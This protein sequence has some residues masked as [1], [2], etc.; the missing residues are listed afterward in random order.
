MIIIYKTLTT[1]FSTNKK[2]MDSIAQ[3]MAEQWRRLTPHTPAAPG[4]ECS[5]EVC[6]L[7]HIIG[8]LWQQG[9]KEHVCVRVLCP[10]HPSWANRGTLKRQV[11]NV[12]MCRATGCAHFC[13]EQCSCTDVDHSDGGHVC[14]IS[15]IRYDSIKSD[16][17]FTNHRVTATH[18]ENKDPL[19]LVRDTDFQINQQSMDTIRQQQHHSRLGKCR[20]WFPTN[21]PCTTDKQWA[22]DYYYYVY[23]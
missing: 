3:K 23:Y 1:S 8:G 21:T 10:N 6:N 13:N 15:G 9:D 17:W 22:A 4:H 7:Q 19:K 11:R 2:R 12:Y 20:V 16:T 5:M 18:Q 14:R